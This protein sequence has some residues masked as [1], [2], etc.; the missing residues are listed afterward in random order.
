MKFKCQC[1]AM[2]IDQTDA[3]SYKAYLLADQD[4]F[5]IAEQH[6]DNP[7]VQLT[8][9]HRLSRQ[10]FQCTACHR[11]YLD[12]PRRGLLSFMP[13]HGDPANAL[14]STH[15]DAYKALLHAAWH[16]AKADAQKGSLFWDQSGERPGG[17]E[18]HTERSVLEKRYAEVKQQLL[19]EGRLREARLIIDGQ[20][21]DR[22]PR[23]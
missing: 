1:G 4:Y 12:D 18:Q 13:E 7:S 6:A 21:T 9:M 23:D 14:G 22:W 20:I 10:A 5:A 11:L 8:D 3:L 2:I 17:F 19:K 15:G 16:G